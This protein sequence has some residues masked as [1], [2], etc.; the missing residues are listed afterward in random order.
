[1]F[2]ER[3]LFHPA[4]PKESQTRRHL[5]SPLGAWGDGSCE[6]R[7]G[8]DLVERAMNGDIL[9]RLADPR[10]DVV[11]TGKTHGF[12]K[13]DFHFPILERRQRTEIAGVRLRGGPV[14]AADLDERAELAL[15]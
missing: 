5:P 11:R 7:A 8:F 13:R 12:R 9:P 15:E 6:K 1:M 10:L 3:R 2:A 14:S 4:R